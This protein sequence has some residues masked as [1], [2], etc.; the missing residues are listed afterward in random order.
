MF[1]D[2][3]F[4][5]IK[6]KEDFDKF[7]DQQLSLGRTPENVGR[8]LIQHGERVRRKFRKAVDRLR[9]ADADEETRS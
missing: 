5:G 2:I 7:M 3:L 6:S 4:H 1:N 9:C 8:E